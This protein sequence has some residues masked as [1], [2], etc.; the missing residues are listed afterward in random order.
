MRAAMRVLVLTVMA[1]AMLAAF[2]PEAQAVII[3]PSNVPTPAPFFG[4]V[5]LDSVYYGNVQGMDSNGDVFF[6]A[7]IS[8]AVYLAS[9][10]NP[11][12]VGGKCIDFYY[13]ISNISNAVPPTN[14]DPIARSTHTNFA[15]FVT[16][17]Y[18][19]VTP[20]IFIP[21]SACPGGTFAVGTIAPV[22]ATRNTPSTVGFEFLDLLAPGTTSIVYVIRTDATDYKPGATNLINGAVATRTTFAPA[23]GNITVPETS[24]LTLFGLGLTGIAVMARRRKTRKVETQEEAT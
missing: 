20:G 5:Q 6:T 3:P 15:G 14:V 12:C 22:L 2:A 8:A 11:Y 17:V 24:E 4:G 16:D 1:T 13:Q 19:I 9:N 18:N 23:V 7:T 21:C 10:P